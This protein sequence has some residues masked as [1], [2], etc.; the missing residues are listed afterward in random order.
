MVK[1]K[2]QDEQAAEKTAQAILEEYE[3]QADESN[4]IDRVEDVYTP[5]MSSGIHNTFA[6]TMSNSGQYLSK[7]RQT[8]RS[9]PNL[10]RA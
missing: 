8:S 1:Q 6:V 10:A 5:I 4:P 7:Q 3:K 2:V 9:G